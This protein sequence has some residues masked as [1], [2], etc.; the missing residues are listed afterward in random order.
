M[1]KALS[2]SSAEPAEG[3]VGPM[4]AE[5]EALPAFALSAAS[6]SDDA[7]LEA[8]AEGDR[9][10]F[11]ILMKRYLAPM[12]NLA[13][14]IVFDREQAREIA[15]EGFLRVW[16]HASKWDPDGTAT[17]STWLRCVV[18]NLAISVRR[19]YRP[20]V[21]LDVIEEIPSGFADGFDAI[22]EAD[23]KR[24]VQAALLKLPERQRA[25][26]A[27]YYFDDLPQGQAAEAMQ[28]TAR[29]FDS[30]IVRAR[31][32]LKKHLASLGLR[33]QEVLP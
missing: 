8:V 6:W 5:G 12:V 33:R 19:R 15:Q 2:P 20:Q 32:N 22:V 1:G 30:L 17:F 31:A 21:S 29:A 4:A 14:R 16:K 27:L 25:A 10:A 11:G 9:E 7:L 28:M 18:V 3:F 26:V 13:Q 24:I 23:Q